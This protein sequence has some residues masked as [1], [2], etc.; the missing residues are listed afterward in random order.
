MS[1]SICLGN[2]NLSLL[3][4]MPAQTIRL[5]L[6]F[7]NK[8]WRH[9]NKDTLNYTMNLWKGLH[10]KFWLIKLQDFIYSLSFHTMPYYPI[11]PYTTPYYFILLHT[12]HTTLYY[13]ISTHTIP[14]WPII[15]RTTQTWKWNYVENKYLKWKTEQHE[16]LSQY[17]PSSSP[18]QSLPFVECKH[19]SCL[20]SILAIPSNTRLVFKWHLLY[21]LME[22]V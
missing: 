20:V 9:A 17:L 6:S 18:G 5:L 4:H 11:L 7:H 8:L 10:V 1:L 13:T 21:S 2:I 14:Y 22:S 12:L 15:L 19:N 3:Y 16:E